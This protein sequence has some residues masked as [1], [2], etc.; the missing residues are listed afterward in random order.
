MGTMACDPPVRVRRAAPNH[1][2]VEPEAI[3]M[4][5]TWSRIFGKLD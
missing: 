1:A 2:G 4:L 3:E 5:R